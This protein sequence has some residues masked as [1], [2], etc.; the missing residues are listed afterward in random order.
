M[1][2]WQIIWDKKG[3]ND[4]KLVLKW[5]HQTIIFPF[6]PLKFAIHKALTCY[7]QTGSHS[8]LDEE[9]YKTDYK[10]KANNNIN[11]NWVYDTVH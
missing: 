3:A 10:W 4:E 7:L 8:L 11:I 1:D 9:H 2:E 6:Q 5:N